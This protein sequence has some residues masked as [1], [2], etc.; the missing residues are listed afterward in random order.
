M[1]HAPGARDTQSSTKTTVLLT[2][3]PDQTTTE[4]PASLVLPHKDGTVPNVLIDAIQA[5][6]GTPHLK[7]VS[8]HQV[9]S[10][11]GM[12]ALSVQTE[13]PGMS[14]RKAANAQFHLPGTVSPALS[15]LE[16]ES[17]IM[18]PLNANAHPAKPTTA[19]FALLTV[20]LV[21]FTTKH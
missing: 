7:P 10:G 17:T 1:D 11:T 18:S 6:S 21:N 13:G 19:T 5:G 4:R 8:A 15:A 20:Q 9:N 2:A 16:E 14:T 3:Q 12:P